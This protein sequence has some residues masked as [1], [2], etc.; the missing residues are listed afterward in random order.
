MAS[1]RRR[2]ASVLL[3]ASLLS[4]ATFLAVPAAAT[5][6]TGQ[7][8]VFWGRNKNEGSLRE[9]CDTGTYT[10]AIIS[11]LDV[12]GHGK[13]HLD[14]SGHDVSAVG[15]DIKHCQSKGILVFLSIGGFGTQYSLPSPQSADDVANYIWNAYMLGTAKGVYRPFGDAFVDGV[16]FFIQN[17]A[18][19]NYDELA[20]RLWSYNKG[21]R[22]RT[23]GAGARHGAFHTHIR[24]VLR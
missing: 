21:Y 8:A 24:Q 2:P 7:V 22:A 16:D 19:D 18:P 10:I 9:A 4:A 23:P 11:F 13:Y 5:G 12:F 17:G 1:V 3:L 14:L 15:A 6:K 20:R